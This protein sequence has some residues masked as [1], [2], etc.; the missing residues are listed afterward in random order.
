MGLASSIHQG[1]SLAKTETTIVNVS[2]KAIASQGALKATVDILQ[3]I[4]A[5]I[6][7][8]TAVSRGVVN[9]REIRHEIVD[10][11]VALI[12]FWHKAAQMFRGIKKGRARCHN[13]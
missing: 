10:M 13:A 8:F 6:R 9:I 1:E 7:V 3:S 5:E 12:Q 4:Y 2:K 11:L